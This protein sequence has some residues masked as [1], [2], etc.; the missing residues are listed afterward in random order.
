MDKNRIDKLTSELKENGSEAVAVSVKQ[1]A[2][3][4]WR[5]I[6]DLKEEFMDLKSSVPTKKEIYAAVA[7]AGV[8]IALID[9][10]I[11]LS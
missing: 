4:N 5:K 2:L 9:F 8:F 7:G 1:L 3:L 10:L 11:H 6:D